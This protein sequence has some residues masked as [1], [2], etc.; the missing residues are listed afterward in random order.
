MKLKFVF[1]SYLSSKLHLL[2]ILSFNFVR[3]EKIYDIIAMFSIVEDLLKIKIENVAFTLNTKGIYNCIKLAIDQK[4]WKQPFK[5][6]KRKFISEKD[7]QTEWW[8]AHYLK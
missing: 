8:V 7:K 4:R 2:F 5:F 6:N 1:L 3:V